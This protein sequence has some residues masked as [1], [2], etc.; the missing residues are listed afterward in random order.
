MRE[1]NSEEIVKAIQENLKEDTKDDVS[2][3]EET[4]LKEEEDLNVNSDEEMYLWD[5]IEYK[6]NYVWFISHKAVTEK[7][8][9]VASATVNRLEEP[10]YNHRAGIKDPDHCRNAMI[11]NLS[12]YSGR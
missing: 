5:E 6:T 2:E 4:P 9:R 1:D 10:V 7:Q 12:Q 11:I 8:M 3:E